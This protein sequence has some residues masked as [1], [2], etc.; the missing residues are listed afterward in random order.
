MFAIQHKFEDDVLTLTFIYKG[1]IEFNMSITGDSITQDKSP[2]DWCKLVDQQGFALDFGDL[3]GSHVDNGTV[4]IVNKN[5]VLEFCV[6]GA[7]GGDIVVRI[8]IFICKNEFY[9][10]AKFME[11]NWTKIIDM[12]NLH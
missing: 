1:D 5:S 8:P 3:Y 10:L 11:T 9:E 4:S 12:Q 6:D 2:N 7:R